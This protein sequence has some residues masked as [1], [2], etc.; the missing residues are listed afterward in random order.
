MT[1]EQYHIVRDMLHT[2]SSTHI[3]RAHELANGSNLSIQLLKFLDF[4]TIHRKLKPLLFNFLTVRWTDILFQ[5]LPNTIYNT[6]PDQPPTEGNI[7]KSRFVSIR[8]YALLE[9]ISPHVW[10]A[11]KN[12]SSTNEQSHSGRRTMEDQYSVDDWPLVYARKWFYGDRTACSVDCAPGTPTALQYAEIGDEVRLILTLS[13]RKEICDRLLTTFELQQETSRRITLAGSVV[14][15]FTVKHCKRIGEN[16]ANFQSDCDVQH[17]D[18]KLQ[19][20]LGFSCYP[21]P[22]SKNEPHI[23]TGTNTPCY[24]SRFKYGNQYTPIKPSDTVIVLKPVHQST[25]SD[26]TDVQRSAITATRRLCI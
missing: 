16:L 26:I 15:I 6:P 10:K 25:N 2:V 18:K 5:D 23:S 24:N 21:H 9:M 8:E 14:L 11:I 17:V 12:N 19:T 22:H 4:S 7:T 20:Y 3:H 13:N 1:K